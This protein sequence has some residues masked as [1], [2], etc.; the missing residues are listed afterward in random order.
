MCIICVDLKAG[1]LVPWEA[2]RNRAEMIEIIDDDHHDELDNVI[3]EA[4]V[5]YLD[6]LKTK[7][8][9][10]RMRVL[11]CYT[12]LPIRLVLNS[13]QTAVLGPCSRFIDIMGINFAQK[14][15]P[16]KK[17]AVWGLNTTSEKQT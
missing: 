8:K 14:K 13:P 2:A 17:F 3:R 9:D 11:T 6:S 16:A 4:L 5:K 7:D 12:T 10:Q 1:R 15:F